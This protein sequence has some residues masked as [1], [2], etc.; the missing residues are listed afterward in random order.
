VHMERA[1][2]LENIVA[3]KRE[4]V[5]ALP[6]NGVAILNEDE[7]LVKAMANYTPAHIITYGLSE[8]ADLRASNI[9]SMGLNGVSFT[10]HEGAEG[11]RVRVP[12]LGRHSVHTALRAAAVGRVEGLNWE[13]IIA[14]LQGQH[15]QLRLVTAPGPHGSLSLDDAYDASPS[16]MLAARN[17]LED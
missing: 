4:L 11:M 14:G 15:A 3:A 5:E 7:P 16:S 2:S 1:G 9:D 17:L 10:L 13:E 12:L 6:G 8:R